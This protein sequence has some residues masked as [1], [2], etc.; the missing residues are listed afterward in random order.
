MDRKSRGPEVTWTG[1]HVDRKSRGQEV[2]WT[3][4]HV[5]RKQ[6]QITGHHLPHC[7]AKSAGICRYIYVNIAGQTVRLATS[8]RNFGVLFDSAQTMESQVASVAKTCYRYYQI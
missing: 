8:V 1:S 5:D 2:T 3:G 7:E 4:S 6:R